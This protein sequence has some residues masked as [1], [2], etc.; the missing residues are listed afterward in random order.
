M[1]KSVDYHLYWADQ[2]SLSVWAWIQMHAGP[3]ALDK[4]LLSL[5]AMQTKLNSHNLTGNV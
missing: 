2:Q 4:Y 5:Q 1:A 3:K